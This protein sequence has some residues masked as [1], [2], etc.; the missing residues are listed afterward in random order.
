MT[1]KILGSIWFTPHG[2][3]IGIV[4]ITDGF[5]NK[6][7]IGIGSGFDQKKDEQYIAA[8]GVPFPIHPAKQLTGVE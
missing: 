3:S 6:A 1:N 4:V 8:H 2:K 7:Y 5:E